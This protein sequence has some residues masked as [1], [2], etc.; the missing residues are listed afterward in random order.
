MQITRSVDHRRIC[1]F[2]AIAVAAISALSACALQYIVG[3]PALNQRIGETL[4]PEMFV[5]M[6]VCGFV[7][8]AA[9][10][11]AL[12]IRRQRD[13]SPHITAGLYVTLLLFFFWFGDRMVGMW[14]PPPPPDVSLLAPHPTRGWCLKAGVSGRES[15]TLVRTNRQGLRGPELNTPK[16]P[17]EFRVLFLG[18]S[19]IFGFG[20]PEENGIVPQTQQAIR[21]R[22]S[23]PSVVC[24]NAGVSGYATWQERSYFE[25]EGLSLEPNIV[26]LGLSL[27]NDVSDEVLSRPAEFA[28]KPL[29]FE[30]SNSSHWSG[31]VRAAVS[32]RAKRA[33]DARVRA[34]NWRAN[35][36]R[37]ALFRQY[38]SFRAVFAEPMMDVF[39]IARDRVLAE[40]TRIAD[41]CA[42][43]RIP[44]VLIVFS[45]RE[46]A[47]PDM[48]SIR[49]EWAFAEWAAANHVPMFD[50]HAALS[51]HCR[52]AGIEL[53]SLY[54]DEAHF[55]SHGCA[56]IAGDVTGLLVRERLIP[57]QN[58]HPTS[59]P[60]R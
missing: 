19:I 25:E 28:G 40:L 37:E 39:R 57:D 36:E 47:E 12:W 5:S 21:R 41:G 56:L 50:A 14:F 24:I 27:Q 55:T 10:V 6:R 13:V 15:N 45:P 59:E 48:E 9:V 32:I 11:F 31:I 35:P 30:F 52:T 54:M 51:E 17:D 58:P 3:T 22:S 20:L 44:F 38:R 53:R 16:P 43:R 42:S 18:D 23:R 26:V 4:L 34:I 29:E 1:L 7:A 8:A 33:W 49:P 2:V 46:R 60:V